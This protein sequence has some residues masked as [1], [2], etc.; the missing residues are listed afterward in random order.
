M[1]PRGADH[2]P[3]AYAAAFAQRLSS[4][5][6][7]RADPERA[8]A[9]AAYMRDQFHFVGVP[10]P[11]LTAALRGIIAEIGRPDAAELAAVGRSCW[12]HEEREWQYAGC[13]VLRRFARRC[14]D[15]SLL[16]IVAQ[17]IV[18]RSWWDTV[19]SL[20]AVVGELVTAHPELGDEVQSWVGADDLWLVRASILHQLRY[21][22]RTDAAR[23]FDACERQATHPDFFIRKAIGWALRQYA[24]TDPDWVRGFVAER[25]DALSGLSR[26]EA[27][28]HL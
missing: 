28:K 22:E 25:A 21:G 8:A 27:L 4:S 10:T 5:L 20:A 14:S 15:P 2:D 12:D 3:D 9:M 23:L 26:R 19:D 18:T 11:P 17:L 24:R 1:T 7:A 16:E 6:A 13:W